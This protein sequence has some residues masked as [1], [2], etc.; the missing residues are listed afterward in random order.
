MLD[1]LYEI[2]QL[3]WKKDSNERPSFEEIY[4][5]ITQLLKDL[6]PSLNEEEINISMKNDNDNNNENKY[7]QDR[8]DSLDVYNNSNTKANKGNDD[9]F[10]P[11]YGK[12]AKQ[13]VNASNNNNNN[14]G[15]KEK[16][17]KKKEDTD[18]EGI[19][20]NKKGQED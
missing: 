12:S 9:T 3:C 16:K 13:T 10:L 2:M 5:G 14:Y 18:Y 7:N 11:S 17:A 19:P 6:D 8:E 20:A 15:K 4:L 1:D